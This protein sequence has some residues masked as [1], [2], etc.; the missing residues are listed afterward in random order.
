MPRGR[1]KKIKEPVEAEQ[2][3]N[4]APEPEPPETSVPKIKGSTRDG[5]RYSVCVRKDV[6]KKHEIV[7]SQVYESEKLA[8]A[9]AEASAYSHSIIWDR[10]KL[11]KVSGKEDDDLDQE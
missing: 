2:D 10:K 9:K 7:Y 6:A 11:A 1:P 3:D 4:P 5:V 8:D